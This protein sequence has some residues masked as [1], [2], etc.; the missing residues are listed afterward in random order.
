MERFRQVT[1]AG[2]TLVIVVAALALLVGAAARR[3]GRLAV[4]RVRAVRLLVAAAGLQLVVAAVA[5]GWGWLRIGSV[6]LSV[7]LVGL[8]LV[9][10]H[11]LAGVP[12]IALGLLLNALVIGAN[13]AMPVSLAAASR[14]GVEAAALD[15]ADDPMREPVTRGTRLSWL[16]DVVPVAVPWRPQV[17]S[18]GDVLVAAGV[19]LM[20]VSGSRRPTGRSASSRAAAARAAAARAAA[21]RAGQPASR[22]DLSMA[23]ESESTTRGSYS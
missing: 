19:G 6:T 10:N 15:L 8:F 17:V 20:L 7:L 2:V 11:R 1:L 5:P 21:G 13:A 16:G 3:T 9:G 23:L 12:L 14:A 22:A 18:P 4:M